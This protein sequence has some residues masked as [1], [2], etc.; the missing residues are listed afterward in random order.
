MENER[1]K[2][3]LWALLG[4]KG[5]MDPGARHPFCVDEDAWKRHTKSFILGQL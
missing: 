2:Q 5:E 1:Q 4:W 3:R